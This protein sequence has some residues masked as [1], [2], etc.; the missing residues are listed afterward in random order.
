MSRLLFFYV[1]AFI[2]GIVIKLCE[3][4]RPN[5]RDMTLWDGLFEGC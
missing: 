2:Y 1:F 5:N 4:Y 3:S